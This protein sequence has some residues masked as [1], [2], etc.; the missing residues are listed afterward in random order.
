MPRREYRLKL[1][2]RAAE[3][4]AQE[5]A[6]IEGKRT[7]AA[8]ARAAKAQKQADV[9][10]GLIPKPERKPSTRRRVV[11]AAPTEH[12]LA[13]RIDL[14]LAKTGR[15]REDLERET[16]ISIHTVQKL[17]RGA[18]KTLRPQAMQAAATYLGVDLVWLQYGPAKAPGE[19]AAAIV[20]AAAAPAPASR[21]NG[22]ARL[23][24]SSH[25]GK[26]DAAMRANL[27][28]TMASLWG[29]MPMDVQV[30]IVSKM[31]ELLAQQAQHQS[32]P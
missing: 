21:Q 3:A 19:P 6:R 15:T 23:N 29:L 28:S 14:T 11:R 12:T 5:Q 22:S 1:E 10:A 9:A 24:G 25:Q 7:S 2:Q 20:P 27:Q 30:M 18:S 26:V 13:G 16:G 4:E 31:A 32:H 17:A 8:N